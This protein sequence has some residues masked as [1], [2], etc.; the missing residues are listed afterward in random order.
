MILR[1]DVQS[2]RPGEGRMLANQAR[3]RLFKAH[4]WR[5][6]NSPVGIKRARTRAA[7]G[8]RE[9][10]R[11]AQRGRPSRTRMSFAAPKGRKPTRRSANESPQPGRVARSRSLRDALQ[12]DSKIR[13][14]RFGASGAR[15]N[16]WPGLVS[17]HAQESGLA[18]DAAIW[19]R[20]APAEPHAIR[21][22][23]GSP[24]SQLGGPKIK[25]SF[26]PVWRGDG[27]RR[28]GR[29]GR[30]GRRP[31][32]PWRLARGWRPSRSPIASTTRCRPPTCWA[33]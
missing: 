20:V 24:S 7:P 21:R 9:P 27:G 4:P 32:A 5:E 11:A 19:A 29:S 30:S 3:H 18:S 8:S 12:S 1:C 33:C 2:L 17:R 10:F 13:G 23:G 16:A 6:P 25:R 31:E 14:C 28:S 22:L 15:R 26:G